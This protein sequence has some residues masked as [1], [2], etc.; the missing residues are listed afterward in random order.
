VAESRQESVHGVGEELRIG[1]RGVVA[2]VD[3]N[4]A[5]VKAK[6]TE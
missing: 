6:Q 2:R 3:L 1:Q 5:R 4:Y